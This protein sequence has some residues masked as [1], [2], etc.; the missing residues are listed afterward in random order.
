MDH[1]IDT[2]SRGTLFVDGRPVAAIEVA[3]TRRARARGLLGAENPSG[4]LVLRPCRSV[5]TFGMRFAIDVAICDRTGQV[6]AV[7]QLPP[8][9]ITRPY[10]GGTTVVEATAGAFERWG[11]Q[12]GSRLQI[13]AATPSPP[14]RSPPWTPRGT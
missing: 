10:R 5:H 12:L 9:R 4:A 7:H 1:P 8:G 3:T 14:R 13:S 2:A 11:L 6:V